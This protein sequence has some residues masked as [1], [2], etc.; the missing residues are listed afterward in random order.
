MDVGHEFF[1]VKFDQESDRLKV[2]NRRPW[3]IYD[4]Y[5]T[6][7]TWTLSF[8]SSTVKIDRTMVWVR[9]L[10][11]NVLF[12]DES[13]LLVVASTLGSLIKVDMNTLKV[14]RS[15]F[16]RICVEITLN[17]PV[18]GKVWIHIFNREEPLY[19]YF[20]IGNDSL[21][22]FYD[23][24]TWFILSLDVATHIKAMH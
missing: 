14:E 23:H 15:R 11:L 19:F 13:S 5:L 6:V 20:L 7:R 24:N 22:D 18:M 17:Q 2:I 4:F 8:V 16:A 1:M 21:T 10:D 3:M 9:L 12:Y